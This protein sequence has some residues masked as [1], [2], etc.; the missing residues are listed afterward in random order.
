MIVVDRCEK[1]T[2]FLHDCSGVELGDGLGQ[3]PNN[4]TG[5][6]IGK[7]TGDCSCY[8]YA[9]KMLS[10]CPSPSADKGIPM[11]GQMANVRDLFTYV[12]FG[13]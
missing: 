5:T 3:V 12:K 6:N 1:I 9:M 13:N 2:T 8:V 4:Y 11:G 7:N 10:S